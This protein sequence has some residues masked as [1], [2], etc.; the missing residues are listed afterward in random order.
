MGFLGNNR[1]TYMISLKRIKRGIERKSPLPRKSRNAMRERVAGALIRL[2]SPSRAAARKLQF[3]TAID[4]Y[5]GRFR[6]WKW[7]VFL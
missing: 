5:R 1:G 7:R 4:S 3:P 2:K 6:P